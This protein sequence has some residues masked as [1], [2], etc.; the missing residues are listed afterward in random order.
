MLLHHE[1]ARR[2]TARA[3]ARSAGIHLILSWALLLDPPELTRCHSSSVRRDDAAHQNVRTR[4][5]VP[6]MNVVAV[7]VRDGRS[8]G[9]TLEAGVRSWS[10]RGGGTSVEMARRIRARRLNHYKPNCDDG[11]R[12]ILKARSIDV[13]RDG[14]VAQGLGG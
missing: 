11:S 10:W 12:R 13:G 14:R 4:C 9:W 5:A 1:Y 8:G 6:T 7:V 3:R 2:D